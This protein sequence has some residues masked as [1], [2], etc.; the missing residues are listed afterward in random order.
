MKGILNIITFWIGWPFRW[1]GVSVK[2]SQWIGYAVLILAVL[3]I[4]GLVYS[5][6]FHRTATIDQAKINAKNKKNELERKAEL[7][8]IVEQNQDVIRTNDNRTAIAE[9]HAE[10]RDKAIEEKVKAVDTEIQKIKESG[11][12]VTQ[13][14]L[15][16]LLQPQT[17][18]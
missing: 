18:Q 17:C 11:R 4:F 10:D 16:C 8:E 13:A 12:D 1:F 3:V 6:C 9:Q 14:E 5:K 2:V 15:T 7:K